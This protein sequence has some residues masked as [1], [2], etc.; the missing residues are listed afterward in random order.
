MSINQQE[1]S[2]EQLLEQRNSLKCTK[3]LQ[4]IYVIQNLLGKV[5]IGISKDVHGRICSLASSSGVEINRIC[6]S[7]A[8]SNAKEVERELHT[9]FKNEREIGEWFSVDFDLVCKSL[10]K[11]NFNNIPKKIP[12]PSVDLFD[13]S[14]WIIYSPKQGGTENV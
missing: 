8:C 7:K 9:L 11:E 10:E 6:V 14:T 13:E 5:K 2:K 1:L 4:R 12:K 3:G